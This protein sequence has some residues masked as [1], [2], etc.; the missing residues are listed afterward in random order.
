MK[1]VPE[2][3]FR[4]FYGTLFPRRALAMSDDT[5]MMR[6]LSGHTGAAFERGEDT[7]L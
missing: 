6:T 1:V 3:T 5:P 2:R 7:L 4:R